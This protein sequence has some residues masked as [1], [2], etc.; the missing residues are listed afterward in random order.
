MNRNFYER[1]Q[2]L[3]YLT[4]FLTMFPKEGEGGIVELQFDYVTIKVRCFCTHSAHQIC[5]LLAFQPTS[6]ERT[7]AADSTID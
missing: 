3:L 1:G 5:C 2:T 7:L 6:S 4:H